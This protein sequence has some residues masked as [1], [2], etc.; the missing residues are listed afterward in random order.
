MG[1]M[2]R[3]FA[4]QL[5]GNALLQTQS[6]QHSEKLILSDSI[7]AGERKMART[8]V[9]NYGDFLCLYMTGTFETITYYSGE[10]GTVTV[11]N[12]IDYLRGQLIDSVG[13]R[14]L[15]NDYIPF[16][17]WLSPGRRRSTQAQNNWA[18]IPPVETCGQSNSLFYPQEFEYIFAANSEI[19]L[20][21]WNDAP[22]GQ[23][24]PEIHYEICFHG[25]R[26]LSNTAVSGVREMRR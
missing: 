7:P 15:F 4:S 18:P 24:A 20:D 23:Y 25:I 14:K 6:V 9:S 11:D 10:G 21:V 19:L 22:T 5:N 12:G 16:S 26:I 17:L 2:I 1:S 8:S 13:Q 3:A